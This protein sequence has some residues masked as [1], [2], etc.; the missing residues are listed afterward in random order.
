MKIIEGKELLDIHIHFDDEEEKKTALCL[1]A[2]MHRRLVGYYRDK[3]YL[4]RQQ[5]ICYI[6]S[7]NKHT[8]LYTKDGVYESLLRLYQIEDQLNDDFIRISKSAIL[9]MTHV[10]SMR[11]DFGSRIQIFMDNQEQLLVTRTYAKAFKQK[12]KGV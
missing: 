6:T 9:N 1:L 10:E 3:E 8:W 2:T 7:W 4:L 12:L 5:D 11:S